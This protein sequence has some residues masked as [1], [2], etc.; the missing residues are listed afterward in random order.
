VGRRIDEFIEQPRITKGSSKSGKAILDEEAYKEI[1]STIQEISTKINELAAQV[2]ELREE[3]AGRLSA[4]ERKIEELKSAIPRDTKPVRESLYRRRHT[5]K[6]RQV[7]KELKFVM[8]SDARSRLGLSPHK[9]RVE[10]ADEGLVI[11]EA[12]GDFAV[13]LPEAFE[14]FKALL[15]TVKSADPAEA[16]RQVG[17]YS[18][19]F[20]ALREGG[21]VYYDARRR[22]W[23]LLE[24]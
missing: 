4:I 17:E 16:A 2:A 8:A 21:Q 9:L 13:L 6:L 3:C 24:Q 11:L 22:R 5:P 1:I 18:R 10:A 12:G 23:I 19:L 20:Q 14:E 7:L 15:S